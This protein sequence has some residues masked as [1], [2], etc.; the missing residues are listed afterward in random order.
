MARYIT[1]QDLKNTNEISRTCHQSDEPLYVMND[2]QCDMVIM[3]VEAYEKL[4]P[5]Y[6]KLQK[7]E[8]ELAA[9]QGIDGKTAFEALRT[10]YE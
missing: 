1:L 4:W 9:C 2:D 6:E 10:K 7:A 3:S 5:C 8:A